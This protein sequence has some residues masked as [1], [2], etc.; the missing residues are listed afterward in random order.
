[1]VVSFEYRPGRGS[2]SIVINSN[3]RD[4]SLKFLPV[5]ILEEHEGGAIVFR[6][7]GVVGMGFRLLLLLGVRPKEMFGA[8]WSEIDLKKREWSLPATR[9]KNG[10]PNLVPLSRPARDVLRELKAH[11]NRSGFVFSSVQRGKPIAAYQKHMTRVR[12]AA[13]LADDWRIYDLRAACLTGLQRLGIPGAVISA[14]ANHAP[15]NITERHYSMY[16]F[17]SEKKKALDR[18]GRHVEKLDPATKADVVELRR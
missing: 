6:E 10:R 7:E 5:E 16:D 4:G 8:L 11:D 15:T 3:D 9:S 18:W 1:M 12:E 2:V 14:V 13:R 17:L